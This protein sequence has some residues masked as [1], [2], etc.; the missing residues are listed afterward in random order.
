MYICL[1]Q[2]LKN[3]HIPYSILGLFWLK[4]DGNNPKNLHCICSC[5]KSQNFHL[6]LIEPE[7]HE[8][9][10]PLIAFPYCIPFLFQCEALSGYISP[11]IHVDSFA[12]FQ[13]GVL[14]DKNP[15]KEN[16]GL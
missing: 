15:N 7:Q 10:Q 2:I 8:L 14:L 12:L 16:I 6:Q 13:E 5:L 9:L 1:L 11:N 4:P 3:G